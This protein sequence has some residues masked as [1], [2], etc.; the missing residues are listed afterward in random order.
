MMIQN[1]AFILPGIL[2]GSTIYLLV[3]QLRHMTVLPICIIFLISGFPHM[4]L[5]ATGTRVEDATKNGW[6]RSSEPA[7]VWYHT[8]DY[9]QFDKVVWSALPR[10]TMSKEQDFLGDGRQQLMVVF[11]QFLS[12]MMASFMFVCSSV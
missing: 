11:S 1:A 4:V 5:F 6:I 12:L 9:L 10:Q 3:R 2:G 7:S 8:W